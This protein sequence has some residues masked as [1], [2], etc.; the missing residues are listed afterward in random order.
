MPET[1]QLGVRCSKLLPSYE[2][3]ASAK[4]IAGKI[5]GLGFNWV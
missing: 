4:Y 5:A 2:L 1:T 3:E